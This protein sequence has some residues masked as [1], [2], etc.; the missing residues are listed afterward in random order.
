M[1]DA[2]KGNIIIPD[3]E[4]WK[5]KVPLNWAFKIDENGEEVWKK[6]KRGN[7]YKPEQADYK[8]F[9]IDYLTTKGYGSKVTLSGSLHKS[10]AGENHS[11]F[12]WDQL[13]EEIGQLC[14]FLLINPGQVVFQNLEVGVNIDW[15]ESPIKFLDDNL[16]GFKG[17]SMNKYDI[18]ETGK[19]IGYYQKLQRFTTKIYDKSLQYGLKDIKVLR[20]ENRTEKMIDLK[21]FRITKLSDLTDKK[22]VHALGRHL[23]NKLEDYHFTDSTIDT[24]SLPDSDRETFQIGHGFILQKNTIKSK[25][26]RW[27]IIQDFNKIIRQYGTDYKSKIRDQIQDTW[28]VL[29]NPNSGSRML[30]NNR[31][32]EGQEKEPNLE[33]INRLAE[34]VNLEQNN[35]LAEGANWND[36]T[37]LRPRGENKVWN[38]LTHKY[39]VTSFHLSNP[40][41]PEEGNGDG[42]GKEKKSKD[43]KKKKV[44]KNEKKDVE[45]FEEKECQVTGILL[46]G[47]AK[48]FITQKMVEEMKKNNPENF[49]K[50]KRKFGQKTAH[51]SGQSDTYFIA[52]NIRNFYW[53]NVYQKK[54]KKGSGTMSLF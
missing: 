30:Q 54:A 32:A 22:K 41:L 33:R 47:R 16:L 42:P 21:E 31:H 7:Q 18:D 10:R 11:Q 6:S 14:D 50:L 49:K 4:V 43:L 44:E 2:I 13:Q 29:S 36:L 9:K 17:N 20:F 37:D 12:R 34:T 39:T 28:E 27:R 40:S 48:N 15:D 38:E 45:K 24:N 1:F 3:I 53:N 25:T 52:H 5:K 23:V 26:G 46:T 35:R 51:D 19:S 8:D